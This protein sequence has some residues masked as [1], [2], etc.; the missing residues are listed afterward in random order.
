MHYVCYWRWVDVVVGVL[1]KE[2]PSP[3]DR[4]V[5]GKVR[6]LGAALRAC[7]N[8]LALDSFCPSLGDTQSL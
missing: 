2:V 7:A 8:M 1:A 6:E 4:S 3:Q 5:G